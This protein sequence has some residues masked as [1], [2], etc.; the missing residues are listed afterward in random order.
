M[1]TDLIPV[2]S[3]VRAVADSEYTLTHNDG[4]V[5]LPETPLFRAG[6]HGVIIGHSPYEDV[7]GHKK[8]FEFYKVQWEAQQDR[9][10]D[11]QWWASTFEV[12]EVRQ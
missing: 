9:L 1:S 11:G 4:C 10:Y 5:E 6:E 7:P 12:E 8:G 2:G 3:I